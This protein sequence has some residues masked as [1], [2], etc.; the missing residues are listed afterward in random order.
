MEIETSDI[1]N[2]FIENNNKND[3]EEIWLP[4]VLVLG[5][6]G[7][8]GNLEL[9]ALYKLERE[10][11][12]RNVSIWIGV[13]IGA[14]VSLLKVCGYN[15]VEIIDDCME[16]NLLNDI[17]DIDL[18]RIKDNP[19]LFSNN[20][21][22]NM[23]K[24]RVKKR[25]GMIPTLMQLFMATGL[26]FSCTT[27]NS[28]KLR[29][30]ELN[31]NTEPNLSCVEAAMMSMPLPGIIKPR[32]YKGNTYLDGAIGDAYPVS[33]YDDGEHN[34]LGIYIK[35]ESSSYSSAK[36]PLILLYRALQ[37]LIKMKIEDNMKASSDKCKHLGLK[38]NIIDTTGISL[39]EKSKMDMIESGYRSATV[40]LSKLK[41]PDK[42]NIILDDNEEIP[43]EEDV[44]PYQGVLDEETTQIID[45]LS[46]DKIDEKMAFNDSL[47]DLFM[48]DF[49]ESDE[50]EI[51]M[52]P[53]TSEFRRNLR[54]SRPSQQ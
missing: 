26:I 49:G 28:D 14:P 30:E 21:I 7:A 22:E 46:K 34:I 38:T 29:K 18:S 37:G 41:N 52:I 20:T 35:T 17:E 19:G 9:G 36:Y 39:D 45:I 6:G 42:Y 10:N 2:I 15:A 12:L 31:K 53:V 54:R 27:F 24:L 48:S 4:D 11:F 16:I 47:E 32:I 8:K 40:F 13:S 3:Q 25:F 23:L 1:S 43:L 51:L 5:T 50:E 33:L 44:I